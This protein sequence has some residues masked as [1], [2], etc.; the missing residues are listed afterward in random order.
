MTI[1]IMLLQVPLLS[2]CGCKKKDKL[3]QQPLAFQE[4]VN[5]SKRCLKQFVLAHVGTWGRIQG[6]FTHPLRRTTQFVLICPTEYRQLSLRI[7]LQFCISL[8]LYVCLLLVKAFT[9]DCWCFFFS[10][11][12]N[13]IYFKESCS[14]CLHQSE[15]FFF[16][17]LSV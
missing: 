2:S 7:V 1:L 15:S 3:D 5:R 14:I 4:F 6:W 16:L 12:Y 9:I 10:L 11:L 13:W 8:A 17:M